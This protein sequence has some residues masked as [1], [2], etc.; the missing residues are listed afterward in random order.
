MAN[1]PAAVVG[2]YRCVLKIFREEST[3]RQFRSCRRFTG[4]SEQSFGEMM[5]DTGF[6]ETGEPPTG[7]MLCGA[8]G[9]VGGDTVSRT[10]E[11]L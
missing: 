2:D 7:S 9:N 4:G 8:S 11:N 10:H 1:L 6:V 5:I 3:K